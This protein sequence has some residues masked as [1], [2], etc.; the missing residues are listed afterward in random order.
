MVEKGSGCGSLSFLVDFHVHKHLTNHEC[1]SWGAHAVRVRGP[2]QHACTLFSSFSKRYSLVTILLQP[3]APPPP[4]P[5]RADHFYSLRDTFPHAAPCSGTSCRTC[6]YTPPPR[7]QP[8]PCSPAPGVAP[9]LRTGRRSRPP[10]E[11]PAGPIFSDALRALARRRRAAPS[12]APPPK[13][14]KE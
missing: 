4:P 7:K 6:N 11:C 8:S 5:P 2:H 10:S 13:R 12:D 1:S 3:A 14:A 9:L